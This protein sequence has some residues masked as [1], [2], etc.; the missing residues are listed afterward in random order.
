MLLSYQFGGGET[1]HPLAVRLISGGAGFLLGMLI[2]GELDI[3]VGFRKREL[4]IGQGVWEAVTHNGKNRWA[5]PL[6][7]TARGR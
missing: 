4:H 5:F 7:P 2:V 3:T 6:A 1:I